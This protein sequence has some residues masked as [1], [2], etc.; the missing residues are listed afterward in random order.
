MTKP[1]SGRAPR[2][3]PQRRRAAKEPKALSITDDKVRRKR[4][5]AR[6]TKLPSYQA[7][8]EIPQAGHFVFAIENLAKLASEYTTG[9]FDYSMLWWGSEAESFVAINIQGS[10]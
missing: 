1:P 9:K 2:H 10:R 5:Y 6:E 7:V 4:L 3:P 8:A